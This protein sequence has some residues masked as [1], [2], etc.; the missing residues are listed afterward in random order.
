MAHKVQASS[1]YGPR[2]EPATPMTDEEVIEDLVNATNQSRGS[3]LA[4]LAELDAILERALSAGRI[5]R[6]PNG[7]HFRP[8]MRRDGSIEVSVRVNP[9]M[10]RRLNA[11]F[12]GKV[13][14]AENAGKSEAELIAL[15]N[16]DHPDD[17]IQP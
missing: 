16:A 14:N 3:T 4:M 17:P 6:L 7:M 13:R 1:T 15:W 8:T 9:D 2:I 5:V 12:R 10:V 11:R